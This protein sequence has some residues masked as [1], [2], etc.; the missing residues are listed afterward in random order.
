MNIIPYQFIICVNSVK[1]INEEKFGNITKLYFEY[2]EVIRYKRLL[3]LDTAIKHL[4]SDE[5]YA[6]VLDELEAMKRNVGKKAD[7]FYIYTKYSIWLN[8]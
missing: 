6:N 4:N 5:N 3:T 2:D 7:V 8:G 1:A